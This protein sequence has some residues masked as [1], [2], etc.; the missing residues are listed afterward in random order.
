MTGGCRTPVAFTVQ[1][2][3]RK[4]SEAERV[5]RKGL[6]SLEESAGS[7][8]SVLYFVAYLVA[9]KGCGRKWR[10]KGTFRPCDSPR[11]TKHT[12]ST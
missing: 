7:S 6:A 4:E 2:L 9:R 10:E 3:N 8:T 12:L 11:V 1:K 5:R